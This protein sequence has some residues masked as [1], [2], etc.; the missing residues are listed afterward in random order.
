MPW[1]P[2]P[3]APEREPQPG[4][5]PTPPTPEPRQHRPAWFPRWRVTAAD[6]GIGQDRTLAVPRLLVTDAAIGV[7]VAAVTV[8]AG[9]VAADAGIGTDSGL[10]VPR[11]SGAD[12]GIGVDT[13]RAGIHGHDQGAGADSGL[14][15]PRSVAV[16]SGAA[17][18]MLT[19]LRYRLPPS[20]DPGCGADSAGAWFTP[21]TALRV[22]YTAPGTYTYPIPVWCRYIDLPAVG[23]G[24]GGAGGNNVNA[25]GRGGYPGAWGGLTL[26]RGVDIPWT[27]TS[28]TIVVGS[29]G[30]PGAAGSNGD[31]GPGGLTQIKY[32]TTVL[33]AVAGGAGGYGTNPFQGDQTYGQPPGDYTFNGRTFIGGARQNTLGAAGNPPG[34]GGAGGDGRIFSSDPGGA[35][36]PGAA[37]AIAYQ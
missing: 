27:A 19:G 23:A 35:G 26:Q 15:V 4:W 25:D 6:T 24:G 29:G 3:A 11:F 30:A 36:A 13:A 17:A 22:D 2:T 33:L 32:G 34:C 28:L 14:M 9:L 1:S 7:D 37:F 16:D 21:H 8:I 18:D 5:F 10:I 12:R 31:G 20:T